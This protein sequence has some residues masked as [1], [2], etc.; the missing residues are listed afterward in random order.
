[1]VESTIVIG[2]DA[3]QNYALKKCHFYLIFRSL[4]PSVRHLRVYDLYHL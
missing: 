4:A 3:T 1:M 2:Y